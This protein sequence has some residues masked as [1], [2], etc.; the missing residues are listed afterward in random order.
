MKEWERLVAWF[1]SYRVKYIVDAE[2][3]FLRKRNVVTV[4]CN[5][6]IYIYYCVT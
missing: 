2:R 1:P 6:S 3:N 4:N 5:V